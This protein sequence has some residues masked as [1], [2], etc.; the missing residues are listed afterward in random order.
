MRLELVKDL[1][2]LAILYDSIKDY[3]RLALNVTK[4]FTEEETLQD[5]IKGVSH[6]WVAHDAAPIGIVTTKVKQYHDHRTMLIHLLGGV[7]IKDWIHLLPTIE[8]SAVAFGC[9]DIEI[10]GRAG[11]KKLLPEYKSNRIIL[12]KEL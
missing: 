10:Q 3:I 7:R 12:S 6:L 2:R 11:W 1:D 8:E 5:I 9:K 4:K